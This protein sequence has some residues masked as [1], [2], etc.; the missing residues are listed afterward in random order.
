MTMKRALALLAIGIAGYALL[1]LLFPRYSTA[2]QWQVRLGADEA[3]ARARTVAAAHGF[4]VAGWPAEAGARVQRSLQQEAGERAVQVH[5]VFTDPRDSEHIVGVRLNGNGRPTAV[6]M[7]RKPAPGD[8]VTVEAARPVAERAFGSFVPDSASYHSYAEEDLGP[9]GVRFRWER[10]DRSVPVIDRAAAVVVGNELR[11][12]RYGPELG[13]THQ[14][15]AIDVLDIVSDLSAVGAVIFGLVLYIMATG[16]R[17]VPQRLALTLAAISGLLLLVEL[18]ADLDPIKLA[19]FYPSNVSARWTLFFG[20]AFV[21]VPVGLALGGGYPYARRRFPRQLI[22]FE[23]LL[24]RGRFT[25]RGVG[26]AVLT[27]IAAGG[28]IAVIP[29]LIRATGLL[30]DYRIGDTAADVLFRSGLMPIGVY[31]NAMPVLVSFALVVSFVEDKLRARAG[32]VAALLLAYMILLDDAAAP[33]IA[34]LLAAA[35]V[36]LLY[37]RM[38]RRVD[39]LAA[40]A[41]VTSAAWAVAALTRF[42]QPAASIQSNGWLSVAL[43][44][45]TTIAAFAVALRGSTKPYLPW[46]PRPARAERERIQAEF[47]VA[48]LAQ[49]RMLPATPPSLPGTSIASFCRPARQVGGDLFDFVTMSDGSLGIAVADVSGKGVPAALV[50]TITKGLLLAASDGRSDPLETLADINTGIHSLGHRSTFVTMLFGVFDPTARTFQFVRAGHTPLLWRKAS[51]EITTLSPRGIGVGMTSPRNFSA[52]CERAT[53][54]TTPGDLLILYSDG[55]NEAM[56]ERSE[57][58]GD[59]RLLAIVRDRVTDAM[60]AEDVRAVI[61]DAVDQFRGTAPAHDDMTL[62]VVKT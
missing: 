45:V 57:E 3:I 6:V 42:A 2:A 25:S 24:L 54:T 36:T 18:W 9:E 46:E 62:V 14:D 59:E 16:R 50:M 55:V 29:Y 7:K 60:S 22:A 20:A 37:D 13:N 61:V 34:A 28:W 51:G 17:L 33:V 58:F 38:F 48:H 5:V 12:I 43:G 21:A 32:T 11:D 52:I 47:E 23:E 8:D 26:A 31:G 30:G 41:A 39:L 49:E 56:N 44:A 40:V 1:A 35:L 27:G 19:I 4:D 10:G 15:G 53:I